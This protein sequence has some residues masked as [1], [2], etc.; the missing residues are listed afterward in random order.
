MALD[1][2]TLMVAGCFVAA[3][4]G[5]ILFYAWLQIRQAPALLWWSAAHVINAIGAASFAAGLADP[6]PSAA[7]LG[8][9]GIV[10]SM[11]LYVAGTRVFFHRSP[12]P[13]PIGAALLV[14]LLATA[15][16]LSG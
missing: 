1:G 2:V 16:T 14:W 15:V 11:A 3:L 12:L 10:V 9:G 4:S 8:G 6:N 5:A 7:I 13:W